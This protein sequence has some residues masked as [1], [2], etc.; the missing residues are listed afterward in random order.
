[1]LVASLPWVIRGLGI[2]GT[3]AMLL[4]GGGMY[5][6]N[7]EIVHHLMDQVPA[8]LANLLV[9]ICVGMPLVGVGLIYHKLKGH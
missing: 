3:L 9:G 2:I 4:V 5:V 6:H 1:M 8:L 7:I